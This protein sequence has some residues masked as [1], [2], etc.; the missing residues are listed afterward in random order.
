MKSSGPS[1]RKDHLRHAPEEGRAL[2]YEEYFNLF[3]NLFSSLP[4]RA[5]VSALVNE[6][7]YKEMIPVKDKYVEAGTE[8]AF[9]TLMVVL[10]LNDYQ[11]K[12]R[13]ETHYWPRLRQ[14][15]IDSKVPSSLEEL[16]NILQPFYAKER[17][18]KV[19]IQRMRKFLGSYL[20]RELWRSS[21][22]KLSER[23][24]YIWR[25]LMRIMNQKPESKTIVFSLKTL[26][27]ALMLLGARKID[28]SG[29]DIP[30][31]LRIKKFT[32]NL[33]D[34]EVRYLWKQVLVRIKRKCPEVSMLR[35]DSFLWQLS[36]EKGFTRRVRYLTSL[37]LSKEE[38]LHIAKVLEKYL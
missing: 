16:I 5:W 10:G 22:L 30:V 9:I 26:A 34:D 1:K 8:G 32:P 21:P 14:I 7:E 24:H 15:L 2:K 12:G 33:T 37:G 23:I 35:L 3:T 38:S 31:D 6:P 27:I 25:E 36:G 17:L 28:F 20:A 4:C 29:V 18:G 13:A 11:L 19:K